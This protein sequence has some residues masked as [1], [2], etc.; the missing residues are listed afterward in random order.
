MILIRSMVI[1]SGFVLLPVILLLAVI[2][3]VALMMTQ[4]GLVDSN[5]ARNSLDRTQ[6]RYTVEGILAKSELQLEQNLTCA[7]YSLPATGQFGGN[8]FS[9]ALS[10]NSGSPVTLSIDIDQG[11]GVTKQVS[12][13]VRMYQIAPNDLVMPV[14]ADTYIKQVLFGTQSNYGSEDKLSQKSPLFAWRRTMLKFDLSPLTITGEQIISANMDLYLVGSP[15][16]NTAWLD[17][18]ALSA[19]WN[20][21]QVTWGK[22]TS[23]NW[24]TTSGGDYYSTLIASTLV[25]ESIPGLYSWDISGLTKIWVD[26]DIPNHGV[27]LRNNIVNTNNLEFASREYADAAKHPVLRIKYKC[28]CGQ[29]CP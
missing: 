14:V 25:D 19:D 16:T 6:V 17:L 12:K 21:T 23:F 4:K 9:V 29:V 11:G 10:A 2:A 20:E 24:W 22:R 5:Q 8:D 1:Q 15:E 13:I 18:Y 3:A 26:A 28:E 27:I 7:G